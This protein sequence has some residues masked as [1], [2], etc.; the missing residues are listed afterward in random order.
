MVSTLF[1]WCQDAA[2]ATLVVNKG[3]GRSNFIFNYFR[4]CRTCGEGAASTSDRGW[5]TICKFYNVLIRIVGIVCLLNMHHY[6]LQM[7]E[8]GD[9]ISIRSVQDEVIA[10]VTFWKDKFTEG[11]A[12]KVTVA[13][14]HSPR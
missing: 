7:V 2:T 10:G 13:G 3:Y 1:A 14:I 5:G 11:I 12:I 6:H 9:I 4:S 8:H